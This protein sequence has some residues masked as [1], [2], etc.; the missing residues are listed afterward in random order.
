MRKQKLLPFITLFILGLSFSTN[1]QNSLLGKIDFLNSGSEEAQS[2][3]YTGVLYL[4]NFEYADAA[5]S[6]KQAQEIDPNFAMAYWG[7]AL[8]KNHPIW[9]RQYTDDAISILN[10][11]A[12]TREE[13]AAKI[14][15]LREK[16]YLET[17][18]ILFGTSPISHGKT[19]EE[20]DFLYRDALQQLHEAYPDDHEANAFYGLSILGTAHEGRDFAIYMKAAAVL[21]KV[22]NE[23]DDHPGAAH[24]LIHSFDDP[25]HAPLGLPMA[26]K[27]SKIAPAAAHAQ[28]MT[29]HIFVA[30]GM[31]DDVISANIIARDVQQARQKE[32]DESTTVCGHYPYWLHYG[33]LQSGQISEAKRVLNTCYERIEVNPSNSELW[34]FSVMK[35]RQIIDTQNWGDISSWEYD[36]SPSSPG[37]LAFIYSEGLSAFYDGNTDKLKNS[38]A[39]LNNVRPSNMMGGSSTVIEVH[40][41]QLEALIILLDGNE[42]QAIEQLQAVAEKEAAMPFEF[43]PP[44]II[45]P[46]YELLGEVLF[47]QKMYAESAVAF[48]KQLERTPLRSLSL[49]GLAKSAKMNSNELSYEISKQKLEKN[50][51]KA[52]EATKLISDF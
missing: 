7:E 6:F 14:S 44:E 48:E 52:D 39:S 33:Y 9:Y 43:G 28:H 42:N 37:G 49:M 51:H 11:Y 50:W 17:L 13:R 35:S 16:Q 10:R 30:M 5:R 21:F 8:T 27:Y 45:K 47:E 38:L 36:Y 22:W 40:I 3:F 31:W 1:A 20:R 32:L 24:Y 12:P 41:S 18:E 15:T 4:H 2:A 23:N 25:I 26:E 29:S 19:K 34:H 46:S